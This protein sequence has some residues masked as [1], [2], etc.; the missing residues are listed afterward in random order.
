MRVG[1]SASLSY[2]VNCSF[3]PSKWNWTAATRPSA[4]R[5]KMGP[6]SRIH[7]SSSGMTRTSTSGP[8][9]LR[10]SAS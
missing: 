7:E 3:Q 9:S 8:S 5:T 2:G 4:S 6:L 10:A 1:T